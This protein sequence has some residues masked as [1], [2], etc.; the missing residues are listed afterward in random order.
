MQ[1]KICDHVLLGTFSSVSPSSMYCTTETEVI[2]N[3]N[4]QL[5]IWVVACFN[6][7]GAEGWRSTVEYTRLQIDY[8]FIGVGAAWNSIEFIRTSL[9]LVHFHFLHSFLIKPN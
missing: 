8:G 5:V 3:A 7:I 9:D 6:N 2:G 4:T 1:W